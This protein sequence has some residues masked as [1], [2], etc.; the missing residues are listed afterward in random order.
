MIIEATISAPGRMARSTRAA[1]SSSAGNWT[2]KAGADVQGLRGDTRRSRSSLMPTVA[3]LDL[4]GHVA[5]VAFLGDIPFFA[6]I[7]RPRSKQPST[8]G[9]WTIEAHEGLL[10]SIRDEATEHAAV[11]AARTARCLRIQADGSTSELA[12]V[13]REWIFA[14]RGRASRRHAPTPMARPPTCGWPTEQSEG[15]HRGAHGRGHPPLLRRKVFA[16][17]SHATMAS[18]CVGSPIAGQPV[19]LEWK[20][21]HTGVTFSPETAVSSSPPCRKTRCAAGGSM[22]SRA[23]RRSGICG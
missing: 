4:Q 10:S 15:F 9:H 7:F 12:N 22:P 6:R 16:S 11:R 2:V 19:D 14:G 1:S 5:G 13:P 21:A 17:R 3:P 20:G 8:H 18:R 23:P